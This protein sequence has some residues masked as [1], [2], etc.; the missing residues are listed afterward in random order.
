MNNSE[1]LQLCDNSDEANAQMYRSLVGGLIYLTHTCLDISFLVGMVS[2]FMNIPTKL[3]FDTGRHIQRHISRA[4]NY[5]LYYTPVSNFRLREFK[6][7]D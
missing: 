7:S 2:R 4:L 5:G 1:K 3:H 6:D